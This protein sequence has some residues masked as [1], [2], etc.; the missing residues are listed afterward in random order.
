MILLSQM[1]LLNMNQILTE[2]AHLMLFGASPLFF[3]WAEAIHHATW[4]CMQ[5]P[6]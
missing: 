3:L 6:S 5:V 2:S 4:L 1:A